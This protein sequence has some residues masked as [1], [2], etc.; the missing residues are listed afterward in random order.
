[1]FWYYIERV[2]STLFTVSAAIFVLISAISLTE[3]FSEN[4]T[5]NEIE[6][7]KAKP[8]YQQ[9]IGD[10]AEPDILIIY[11]A[12]VDGVKVYPSVIKESE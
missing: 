1:M 12:E 3:Y 9:R 2:M 8:I 7:T 10:E 6:T 4:S 5:L 11:E